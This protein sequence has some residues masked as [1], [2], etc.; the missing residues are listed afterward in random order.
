MPGPSN[1]DNVPTNDSTEKYRT[2]TGTPVR[3]D[4]RPT[5]GA[6]AGALSSAEVQ[7]GVVGAG[8]PIRRD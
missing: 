7:L 2:S 1:P 5:F 4:L 3:K 8:A 6:S